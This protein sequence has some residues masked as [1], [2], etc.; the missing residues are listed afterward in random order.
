MLKKIYQFRNNLDVWT[1][2][3]DK[4]W[5]RLPLKKQRIYT[6]YMFLGYLIV[7]VL[8]VLQICLGYPLTKHNYRI[9][10]IDNPSIP[11]QKNTINPLNSQTK[12]QD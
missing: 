2:T 3:L 9:E 5:R 12:Q 7:T 8:I 6:I 10:H 11:K 1:N 4:R